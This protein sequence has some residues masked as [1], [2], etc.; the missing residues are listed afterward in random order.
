MREIKDVIIIASRGSQVA[1]NL[2]V[3]KSTA[4]T[5][6]DVSRKVL[7][8]IAHGYIKNQAERHVHNVDQSITSI[9]HTTF[10]SLIL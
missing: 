5:I 9:Y 4:K 2:G 10:L 1:T 7:I 3:A 6:D 8:V